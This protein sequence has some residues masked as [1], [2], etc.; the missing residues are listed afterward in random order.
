MI[1]QASF[2]VSPL[3]MQAVSQRDRAQM[4]KDTFDF[5]RRASSRKGEIAR[6][7]AEDSK[8]SFW[9]F[10]DQGIVSIGNFGV[11]IVLARHF[12]RVHHLSDYGAFWVLMELMIFINGIQAALLV[13]PLSVRGAVLDRKGL[14][15]I[16]S[17]SLLLT[18][19]ISPLL[20]LTMSATAIV[21]ELPLRV[22][23]WAGIALLAWQ[24]QEALRRSLMAHLRFRAATI[25]DTISYAGQFLAAIWLAERGMLT[26]ETAFQAMALT[27]AISCLVQATQVG[28]QHSTFK[29]TL[30]FG[31]ECWHLGRWVLFG[32]LTTFFSG[33]MF[34]WNFAYWAGL[35]TLGI[36]Y[37][38]ANLVRLANPLSFAVAT[39]ITPNA[40]RAHEKYGLQQA[41]TVSLRFTSVGGIL[42]LPYLGLLAAWPKLLIAVLYGWDSA[43]MVYA[44]IVQ[45]CAV[46]VGFVY[47]GTA[48]SAYLNAIHRT[49]QA[50]F[51]QVVYA[52][53]YLLIVMPFTAMYGLYGAACGWLITA[54]LRV[55]IY[56][57]YVN[58]PEE[59]VSEINAMPIDSEEMATAQME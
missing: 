26:L 15:K 38:L 54:A 24:A 6:M 4:L 11:N 36:Y 28:M 19:F 56:S 21:A 5:F 48:A 53:G 33:T 13:Y 12:E 16:T 40:A 9:A 50:F 39:L 57:Y 42:L 59:Q 41:K 43:Y 18:F 17:Q 27:S 46:A 51:G 2:T 49:R 10:A 8:R 37:A 55:A 7:L 34:N 29:Q 58:L 47:L 1:D 45:I 3:T 52:V 23:I 32:N 30:A 22:G 14:A 31:K 25:G 35:E 20:L 44:P